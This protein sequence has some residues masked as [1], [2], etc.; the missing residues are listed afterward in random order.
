[1][2]T[3][4]SEPKGPDFGSGVPL[5]SLAEGTP[6]VGRAGG[7][8]ALLVRRGADVFAI[9]ATCTHYGGPLGDGIVVGGTIRCPYHHAR[10]DL[11][12]G[13]AVG[14]PALNGVPCFRVEQRDGMVYVGSKVDPRAPATM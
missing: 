2:A 7:E 3:Q 4:D 6:V 5:E 1:M 13:E 9:G 8:A 12:T 11:R 14:C 10:F